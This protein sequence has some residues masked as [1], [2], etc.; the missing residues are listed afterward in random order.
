MDNVYSHRST[1]RHKRHA[2]VSYYWDCRLIGRP[3]GTPKSADPGKRKRRRVARPR[4]LCAVKIKIVEYFP[5]SD[6]RTRA[7][8]AAEGTEGSFAAGARRAAA[9]GAGASLASSVTEHGDSQRTVEGQAL[10]GS[11][12]LPHN[13]SGG[14]RYEISKVSGADEH[15]VVHPL[16]DHRH[17]LEE[18]DRIKKSSVVR[19]FLNT[20][21]EPRTQTV[22]LIIYFILRFLRKFAFPNA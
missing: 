12:R 4:D 20:G 11:Y 15:G 16:E 6:D 5:R 21:K 1:Q 22:R 14:K 3:S 18:S 19:H 10:A 7:S 13:R 8:G 17:T 2:F 9:K